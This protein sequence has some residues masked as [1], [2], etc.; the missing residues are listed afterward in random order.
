MLSLA[1]YIDI[2]PARRKLITDVVECT[3]SSLVQVASVL[4]LAEARAAADALSTSPN[5]LETA[6]M[7][8]ERLLGCLTAAK[9]QLSSYDTAHSARIKVGLAIRRRAILPL[10]SPVPSSSTQMDTLILK[11][12]NT[13]LR[14][15]DVATHCLA[16]VSR[17]SVSPYAVCKTAVNLSTRLLILASS[18][19][20]SQG[21][22]SRGPALSFFSVNSLRTALVSG[23]MYLGA[24][25]IEHLYIDP[26]PWV[27]VANQIVSTCSPGVPQRTY[28]MT[29]L[30]GGMVP[31]AKAYPTA[32]RDFKAAERVVRLISTL[33]VVLEMNV[34]RNVRS[35]HSESDLSSKPNSS[36]QDI[37]NQT[38]AKPGPLLG[39]SSI[40]QAA[41]SFLGERVVAAEEDGDE[42][43]IAARTVYQAC[44]DYV[45]RAGESEGVLGLLCRLFASA[46]QQCRNDCCEETVVSLSD[47]PLN[48]A[49]PPDE[50]DASSD[51]PHRSP[52]TQQF[53]L[54]VFDHRL[55]DTL[56]PSSFLG[57]TDD[58][59]D[60]SEIHCH[61]GAL[62]LGVM[63]HWVDRAHL[64]RRYDDLSISD[65]AIQ[66]CQHA[67]L[68][69]CGDSS[70]CYDLRSAMSDFGS[71]L[72]G[73]IERN[74]SSF[75][76]TEQQEK[77]RSLISGLTRS[78]NK[79]NPIMSNIISCCPSSIAVTPLLAA[80]FGAGRALAS[81]PTKNYDEVKGLALDHILLAILSLM[82]PESIP[83]IIKE[84]TEYL[85]CSLGMDM[86]SIST[87]S[88][89]T[90]CLILFSCAISEAVGVKG[91]KQAACHVSTGL[92]SQGDGGLDPVFPSNFKILEDDH[93]EIVASISREDARE[94]FYKVNDIPSLLSHLC[95]RSNVLRHLA[96]SS[97]MIDRMVS[98]RSLDVHS[99]K[100]Q[101]VYY[102]IL[103]SLLS[104][105]RVLEAIELASGLKF[106]HNCATGENAL[107]LSPYL[108]FN[109]PH[110]IISK[111]DMAFLLDGSK[112]LNATPMYLAE[113]IS[114]A[115]MDAPVNTRKSFLLLQ[116]ISM[117]KTAIGIGDLA[118][119]GGRE[120]PE[121]YQRLEKAFKNDS[122]V[123]LVT[124]SEKGHMADADDTTVV[125]NVS[126][127]QTCT[128]LAMKYMR[129]LCSGQV[130]QLLARVFKTAIRL[131]SFMSADD[132]NDS[133]HLL[134]DVLRSFLFLRDLYPVL[135]S[136][137]FM[138]IKQYLSIILPSDFA[139]DLAGEIEFMAHVS[140]VAWCVNND[141]HSLAS[142][143]ALIRFAVGTVENSVMVDNAL[144]VA[145]N[146]KEVPR[147]TASLIEQIPLVLPN[148]SLEK[149]VS[150]LL[151]PMDESAVAVSAYSQCLGTLTFTCE[152]SEIWQC[153]VFSALQT[154]IN[155]ENSDFAE[156][157]LRRSVM[158]SA[159]L[160]EGI[161]SFFQ[162]VVGASKST[163]SSD[164][165][166]KCFR[167][168]CHLF[169][170]E[171]SVNLEG[172][173]RLLYFAVQ[174]ASVYGLKWSADEMDM[175][176]RPLEWELMEFVLSSIDKT[177]QSLREDRS[178]EFQKRA[179]LF[180]CS[181]LDSI[182]EGINGNYTSM[183]DNFEST[184]SL[185][186]KA[187][188][189]SNRGNDECRKSSGSLP[190][191]ISK[192][193]RSCGLP[194]NLETPSKMQLCT[195]TSTGDQYA[196]QHWYFCY[197]CDLAG[198][199][200]VCSVCAR[201]CHKDCELAYSK[202][203]RFFCDC[204]HGSEVQRTTS[205]TMTPSSRDANAEN[206][207]SRS[208]LVKSNSRKRKP[209]LC[210]KSSCR[211]S[212][213]LPSRPKPF[214]DQR[215]EISETRVEPEK[216]IGDS[217]RKE[218]S[219]AL[220]KLRLPDASRA[221]QQ[222]YKVIEDAFRS[223]ME[224]KE[225]V[226]CLL[227]AA[228]LLIKDADG[229]QIMDGIPC[230]WT[231]VSDCQTVFDNKI[232]P[233]TYVIFATIGSKVRP[234]KVLKNGSFD[235]GLSNS[236]SAGVPKSPHVV[237]RGSLIS[238]CIFRKVAAVANKSGTIEFVE[239]SETLLSG[240]SSFEK[241]SLPSYGRTFISFA[242][243]SISFHPNNSNI[244][245]VVGKDRVAVLFRLMKED[246]PLW[247][248]ID[249]E[250]GLSEYEG[251]EGTNKLLSACWVA[252]STSLLLVVSERFVKIFDITVDTFCPCFFAKVPSICTVGNASTFQ[253]IRDDSDSVVKPKF[254]SAQVI[255]PNW[256][257]TLRESFY[258]V[259]VLTSDG[260][261]SLA[262]TKMNESTP[263]VFTKCFNVLSKGNECDFVVPNGLFFDFGLSTIIISLEN[264]DFFLS[265]FS[266]DFASDDIKVGM[267]HLHLYKEALTPGKNIELV[268]SPGPVSMFYFFQRG[269]PFNSGG[270][271][272]VSSENYVEVCWFHSGLSSATLGL[273]PFLE[274]GTNGATSHGAMILLDDG[275]IHKAMVDKGHEWL[276]YSE[277]SSFSDVLKAR[278]I[279]FS[280]GSAG[281]SDTI[282][283]LNPI[284]DPIGFFEKSR[285]VP[286]HVSITVVGE[287]QDN[288]KN[289]EQMAVILAGE[290]GE[291]IFSTKENEPFKFVAS[292][293]NKSLVI[294]GARLR[295]GGT[296]RSRYRVPLEIKVFNRTVQSNCKNGLKRWVDIPFSVPE[297]IKNPQ[298]AIFELIPRP[299]GPEKRHGA[300]GL[301]AVDCLEIHAV[302]DV[303]FT[304]RKLLFEAE[305][306]K[307]IESLKVR[308][309][310]TKRQR[311]TR[312]LL[313]ERKAA[314]TQGNSFC[315]GQAAVLSVLHALR[316][317][318]AKNVGGSKHLLAE[319]N[320][321][322][323]VSQ[324]HLSDS[325]RHFLH[326]L[327]AAC[328]QL[329]GSDICGSDAKQL[330][331]NLPLLSVLLAE[332]FCLSAESDFAPAVQK[333]VFPPLATIESLLFTFG[334]LVR[335]MLLSGIFNTMEPSVWHGL[336]NHV[337]MSESDFHS[338]LRSHINLGRSGRFFYK[339]VSHACIGAVDAAFYGSLRELIGNKFCNKRVVGRESSVSLLVEML[340]GYDQYL[341][342]V[343]TERLLDLFDSLDA[344]SNFIGS[345]LE[346]EIV[347][348]VQQW[349][350][351]E[352]LTCGGESDGTEP[353]LI[354]EA[355]GAQGWA[356]RC[357]SCERVC[358]GE[359]WHCND[360]EDFDLCTSCLRECKDFTGTPHLNSHIMLRGTGEEDCSDQNGTD[361]SNVVP[362][363]VLVTQD[364]LGTIVD[365][366]LELMKSGL[367][368][369][370][371]R[372][373]DAAELVA[374]LVG[375]QS[376]IELRTPRLEALFKSKF[377]N[378][379]VYEVEVFCNYLETSV[380]DLV[381]GLSSIPSSVETL[382]LFLRILMCARGTV[383]PVFIH[384][385]GISRLLVDALPRIHHKLRLYVKHFVSSRS[386]CNQIDPSP[387]LLDEGVWNESIDGLH[388]ALLSHKTNSQS[389][390]ELYSTSNGLD[391]RECVFLS[392]IIEILR[393]LDYAY[394][395]ASS[396]TITDEMHEFPKSVLCDIMTFCNTASE[397][398][399][400]PFLFREVILGA[401]NLLAVLT[402]DDEMVLN[403]ILDT[404]LYKEQGRR[405]HEALQNAEEN[406]GIV[407]YNSTVEVAE[408][409]KSLHL[410][411]SRHPATWKSFATANNPILQDILHSSEL[412][413]DQAEVCALQ[414]LSAAMA[415]SIELA[416]RA[417]SGQ[418]ISELDSFNVKENKETA[419]D[420]TLS[421]R[422]EKEL[423]S[424]LEKS[425]WSVH[426]LIETARD[427]ISELGNFLL[428]DETHIIGHLVRNVML[429]SK[430]KS[431]RRA[432]S[433]IIV[434]ALAGAMGNGESSIVSVVDGALTNG[435][436][437]MQFSGGIADGL[438][439]VLQF[440]IYCCQRNLFGNASASYLSSLAMEVMRLL[441]ERCSAL[442]SHPNA[443]LYCRL[444]E[445]LDLTGYYLESD[446]CT[447]CA[448]TPLES[449]GRRDHRLDSIRAETKYTDQSIMHRLLS[450][451]EVFTISVKV[452]DPRRTKRAKRID[453]F[454][455]TRAVSDATE[456][457]SSEHPWSHLKSIVLGPN[458][459]EASTNL[460]L[461]IAIS[462]VKFQFSEFHVFS[463][464]QTSDG[465]SSRPEQSHV[466]SGSGTSRRTSGRSGDALQCPRCSR[467]VTDRHGICRNCHEN[468]YQCRQ[469]RNINYENLD[470]FL[471]N[472]CGY[473]KHA[474]FEFSIG[475]RL[476]YVA[477]TVRNEDDR[478]RAAKTIEKET[479]SIHHCINQLGRLR[480]SII[481]SLVFGTPNDES[482]GRP[483]LLSST[484]VDLA[485]IL[486][487]V[488]PKPSDI[489][490]LEALLEGRVNQELEE[491]SQSTHG[492]SAPEE[493]TGDNAVSTEA[494]DRVQ[495]TNR[496]GSN[497]TS[498]MNRLSRNESV[499]KTSSA[500]TGF[501][502]V[503][504]SV[505]TKYLKDCKNV[506]SNMSRS[507]CVLTTTRTELVRYANQV[508]GDR[509]IQ[510]DR[511]F[512][513]ES[514]IFAHAGPCENSIYVLD[515]GSTLSASCCYSCS[516][517]FIANCTQLI[518]WI[519]ERNGV[520][521]HL[522]KGSTI[523]KDML[524]VYALCEKQEI[525]HKMRAVISSLVYGNNHS[526]QLVCDELE[527]KISFCIDSYRTVD[528]HTIARFEMSVLESIAV[529]DDCCWEERLKLVVRILFKASAEALTCSAVAEGIILPC[530]RV[531]LRLIQ[532]EAD[533][534]SNEH[535]SPDFVPVLTD[536]N[537]T[538]VLR[539]IVDVG[540]TEN[541]DVESAGHGDSVTQDSSGADISRLQTL[542]PD[543]TSIFGHDN[544]EA[545]G[546][547]GSAISGLH[548]DT[549]RLEERKTS[550]RTEADIASSSRAPSSIGTALDGHMSDE[551]MD[552]PH[553]RIWS[554]SSVL[555][556]KNVLELDHDGKRISA[557][558]RKWL[559][560]RQ[561]HASWLSDMVDRVR[562]IDGNKSPNSS[563]T[564]H[565]D[566]STRL[567]FCRWKHLRG[568]G[569]SNVSGSSQSSETLSNILRIG[570]GNWIVRLM[571]FTPCSAVRKEACTLMKLLC[572]DEQ[573]LHLQLLDILSGPSLHL[574][575]E[576][577]EKSEEFF[578]LLE[579][580][581]SSKTYRL[582]LIG[583]GFLPRIAALILQKAE[584]LIRLERYAESFVPLVNFMEGYSL[585]RLVSLLRITLDVIPAK[586]VCL[587]ERI[588]G[589]DDNKVVRCLQRA[590]LLVQKLISLKT[591][592]TDECAT[593]LGEVLL[594]KKFLFSGSTV[595]AIV[596]AC[597][598]DLR[599][600][601]QR[602]DAQGV[603]LLL[604]ELCSMLCP[605][606]S[607]PTCFLTLNK[608]P[609][610]EE[611]IRGG[612]SRNPYPSSSFDGP[613]MR[614]VKNK[615]CKDLDLPGLL[616]DDFAMELLV[617]GN[618]VKL[619][620]PIMAVYEQIW[621]HAATAQVMSNTQ[622]MNFS[623]SFGLRR[624]IQGGIP[625]PNV[626]FSPVDTSH[627]FLNN[628]PNALDQEDVEGAR[629]EFRNE[630]PM[631]VV[632]RLS[633]L[634]GEATEPIIDSLPEDAGDELSSEELYQ[635]T[636]ILGQVGGF[637]VLFDLLAVVGSWGDDAE[638]A[639]RGPA[640]R[641]LRASCE[642]SQNRTKL[643]QSPVAVSTLL[644]CAA[645]A[646]EHAQG[647][648]A[649]V[650]S[651]ESLLIAAERILAHQRGDMEAR[652]NTRHD[653]VHLSSHDPDEVIARVEMFLER[654]SKAT[655]HTAEQS[656][657]HLLP[658]LIQGMK[659]AIDLV[660]TKLS[661]SW[662][663]IDSNGIDQK[664][665]RQ[666]SSILFATP[667]DL[668]GN[669]FAA[670]TVRAGVPL[671]ALEYI[672][673]KFPMPPAEHNDTWSQS[674][675]E[676]GVPLAL[677]LITAL[678]IFSGSDEGEAGNLLLEILSHQHNIISVLCQL[679]MAVSDNSI[680][681]CAE[682]L[683][684][685]LAR[686][687]NIYTSVQ[688]NR[689]AIRMAR[690][691]AALA[692]RAT[693]LMEAGL[694]AFSG[695]GG[696]TLVKM[697]NVKRGLDAGDE[698][699][700]G[701]NT[702]QKLM[703]ELP[704]EIG[705]SC[706]VCGDGFRCR[707][708]EAL[709]VYVFCRKLPLEHAYQRTNSDAVRTH[710][711]TG[712]PSGAEVAIT[713]SRSDAT[714]SERS[715]W[716]MWSGRSRSNPSNGPRLGSSSFFSSLTH[717]NAI[718][719][720][721]HREAARVDRGSRR[722]EW[723]GA[724]LRN[725]Q[726][727][728]NNLLPI[729]PPICFMESDEVDDLFTQKQANTS[730][731]TAVESYFGRLTSH[732][733]TSL[734]QLKMVMF[735]LGRSFLR[736]ADGG[737]A[738]FS[739][740][741]KGGGPHSNAA[742]IPHF[743]Q[744]ALFLMETNQE[745]RKGMDVDNDET[746]ID[747]ACVNTQ[748]AA[749]WKY[750]DDEEI[751]DPT[752]Y[753]A[754][755]VVLLDLDEWSERLSAFAS[756]V[757]ADETL[758]RPQGLRLIAFADVV[759]RELKHGMR[760]R[761]GHHWL[762]EFKRH[763]GL[764]ESF[765]E[766]FADEVN[767]NW[768]RYIRIIEDYEGLLRALERNGKVG[769]DKSGKCS[770]IE[771][772]QES[773]GG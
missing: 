441:K 228:L 247:H 349:N 692:S 634:D 210:L 762:T 577:G 140:G 296:E 94:L 211:G 172:R 264:G 65:F 733:R 375:L 582:Y 668:R 574:G 571:L 611:F 165:L 244:L 477:E 70:A 251:F 421:P 402:L 78:C 411:A 631:V 629:S 250:V 638:T 442:V 64:L 312:K 550:G 405:L 306:A 366:V 419:P 220:K 687:K 267:G 108:C 158:N 716:E 495:T 57:P 748:L 730:F 176:I 24:I 127:I 464:L 258:F 133:K 120:A 693:V 396:S 745:G 277:A 350:L 229:R 38:V 25:S 700:F 414:L 179:L 263:P 695:E 377:L 443:R 726:T 581:L 372:F 123:E 617:A 324:E 451:Y 364:L 136:Y 202:F 246:A 398:M 34:L 546:V 606:R 115:F 265:H 103:W 288:L 652:P 682:E 739:E 19:C 67:C 459:T 99:L 598:S 241:T 755:A 709:A 195:Y 307:H 425:E 322:C 292:T 426:E 60:T 545:T 722:D 458:A 148:A 576:V 658:F 286:E 189:V 348:A 568:K 339:S 130:P 751:G 354:E 359:W 50:S 368:L 309:D 752:Y 6:C 102:R 639:V 558:V 767:H 206:L 613:L 88:Y 549:A 7:A 530:L 166:L 418:S 14:L 514:G 382:L 428:V 213:N 649:A 192:N 591:R 600:A 185:Q 757:L 56:G 37:S 128:Q 747:E 403:D 404:C 23:A 714:I 367:S 548:R 281:M 553:D 531:A 523:A 746:D 303:E 466:L 151:I 353:E 602:N 663:N 431:A 533:S 369:T 131:L 708:E 749:L 32:E 279:R 183:F 633:G 340:C 698:E 208:N 117:V 323:R 572:G 670:E 501:N 47:S 399:E 173:S 222:R 515:D 543:P 569:T 676:E 355:D 257:S 96:P 472:E 333:R 592:L 461:P 82:A 273:S 217:L 636:N 562:E 672:G 139:C 376:P 318:G 609:T 255:H 225:V 704:D 643:A 178:S 559:Q 489:A 528:A 122:R 293:S 415:P 134:L 388:Y 586:K 341:R 276:Q 547:L 434:F 429:G 483:K 305:K 299:S 614:D 771:V 484:R 494:R 529:L 566:Q 512:E 641:L 184:A 327:L 284:P 473:C 479:N 1:E 538:G 329:F 84:S 215:T 231:S 499:G 462:N 188:K 111:E 621:R 717:M 671:E 623:R 98:V 319:A 101:R 301:V 736:F 370:N 469:C 345:P 764:D 661:F 681:T 564:S 697:S 49:C 146:T 271:F 21:F 480:T 765:A 705:P 743:V 332:G 712:S 694:E 424:N 645:S 674:L 560:G 470:G 471:C 143:Q 13:V 95:D 149:I 157:M 12:V 379:L 342:L 460:S 314:S 365:E 449:S 118:L 334:G 773:V 124:H 610:Q 505:A 261:L 599:S 540:E 563:E 16:V 85:R 249:I 352:S 242:I 447:T 145:L 9:P 615:I 378:A 153:S 287:N 182:Q 199:D 769:D 740:H 510:R 656:I 732:G 291:C 142:L 482:L 262:K 237:P 445:V 557:D 517:S 408:V 468:A 113:C 187:C 487:S 190:S 448:M 141:P 616:E 761:H 43:R 648:S 675:Q 627:P 763:I 236:P 160:N 100:F 29:A 646:F 36:G 28:V 701:D 212:L 735:D 476:T 42:G 203:S 316:S 59:V 335:I 438:M 491:A 3:G 597:V 400:D 605:E 214:P 48:I 454:Y 715:D 39:S 193:E 380:K 526:T 227:D 260:T 433:Q 734:S 612:M 31:A 177:V 75:S 724:A 754:L 390:S 628:R 93:T 524:L 320:G 27:H 721:C 256:V 481:K 116:L 436:K 498:P 383:M 435:L 659:S 475:G 608:A 205:S 282:E 63:A 326:V 601:H 766:Q 163:S 727:K 283:T 361:D 294:V 632:Y 666:L 174:L 159:T 444:S 76:E 194:P 51:G 371:W 72:G 154:L 234:T 521:T 2:S 710:I 741:T 280:K 363:L 137:I 87:L 224:E 344:P 389:P 725:S 110:G 121:L 465:I 657:L 707:P 544:S 170:A 744:L 164:I 272:T 497:F 772:S 738:I 508:G 97:I 604:D 490:V 518:L 336:H 54:D 585:K 310:V 493:M 373:L 89:L 346:N 33:H 651:A 756:R 171:M 532:C 539:E 565:V 450:S 536:G 580:S 105:Q 647:S 456:L 758:K 412:F 144:A 452:I 155:L 644:E 243:S 575:A 607:E 135:S 337:F 401:K 302:S 665:A 537:N 588:L 374:Q 126:T 53:P 713:T 274:A 17:Q 467:T 737:T 45:E 719:A 640:L 463:D 150:C 653:T 360:C 446:P 593:Q 91:L 519:L 219:L 232:F 729:R 439:H 125:E 362:P 654:L 506:Y 457:K 300:D 696:N 161:V 204:G 688:N 567:L 753:L 18:L 669:A 290:G 11:A 690:K 455:S 542:Q 691:E 46:G 104:I 677:Q 275:S 297:S 152:Q 392:I 502:Q 407:S 703:D 221:M 313:C 760:V 637:D 238:Y 198:S 622:T 590:Y 4:M 440:F 410:A 485:D 642:V 167:A 240:D 391:R 427:G 406:N 73:V 503:T 650:A 325:Y 207:A 422:E 252:N 478:R 186:P 728:C 453:V 397:H 595:T 201:V 181:L 596:G 169:E 504:A 79:M 522:I 552:T 147:T 770:A 711:S 430:T 191:S 720:G 138:F 226:Q 235:V 69:S 513:N 112:D 718:H 437:I 321:L 270:Y 699:S 269:L 35:P 420:F 620:L 702:L 254:V 331:Q 626:G 58:A 385:H 295:F 579:S 71:L 92:Y 417:I 66:T 239:M 541:D 474:R 119:I 768:E 723:D 343:T 180:L 589:G 209:C 384:Q 328:T 52:D 660:L 525:Q 230:E 10:S 289:P 393:V 678:S 81:L 750:L 40:S 268:G 395:S 357:D 683:L 664:K 62:V 216:L 619:D 253:S 535:V 129:M 356:Y 423:E 534:V 351:P 554:N 570:K 132:L 107:E 44:E 667:R 304:E 109:G 587:R 330:S 759:S 223:K 561:T 278:Q 413:P 625:R 5:D 492:T 197:T 742:L 315:P 8:L 248:Q 22:D 527:R 266:L 55:K 556:L 41:R 594:S 90:A 603:A 624:V 15:C 394:R 555:R 496:S 655:S 285:V 68:F 706:V 338:L 488:S 635:D 26:M 516:Q 520:V 387:S 731:L 583:K 689:A 573:V 259:L 486:G 175:R 162:K 630:P 80:F 347:S 77:W 61:I 168:A 218:I 106:P 196:E 509:L 156:R 381:T 578:D 416:S 584:R 551:D 358:D 20:E 673:K 233:D 114:L 662:A 83:E 684:E 200:G 500:S 298:Q 686:D 30:F 86:R 317:G 680:G 685:G 432:A 409:L 311:D 74:F 245:L 511:V 618:V 679:E 308:K 386:R 507:I